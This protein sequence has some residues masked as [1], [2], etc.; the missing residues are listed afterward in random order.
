MTVLG[1][2][3]HGVTDWNIQ[4]RAQGHTDIPLNEEGRMQAQKLADRLSA[5]DWDLIYSSDLSRAQE[6]ALAIAALKQLDVIVDPMLREVNLGQIEGMTHEEIVEKWGDDWRQL[7]LGIET[8][9]ELELRG[10][11]VLNR[12]ADKHPGQSILVVA[13]GGFIGTTLKQLV[14]HVDTMALLNNT[15]ITRISKQ[16]SKWECDLFNCTI[17]LTEK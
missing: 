4:K 17:H 7:D 11:E 14:A 5:E 12:I 8:K 13:H 3:R 16:T 15:S 1:L 9:E 6:T 2:I 10:L